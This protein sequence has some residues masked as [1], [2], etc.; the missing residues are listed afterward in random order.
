MEG[1]LG[2][3]FIRRFMRLQRGELD[4]TDAQAVSRTITEI[5]PAAV[6]LCAG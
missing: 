4:I 5:K 6:I 3:I 2:R 1:C